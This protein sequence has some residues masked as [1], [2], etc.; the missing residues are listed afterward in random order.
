MTRSPES[1]EGTGEL[2]A[3][4]RMEI[5]D[6]RN[7]ARMQEIVARHGWLDQS[8]VGRDGAA[9]AWCLVQ[10]ADHDRDFQRQYLA[11][12]EN[13][14]GLDL[15]DRAHIAYL[16][17]RIR[18]GEER[19]QLYGTQL[20]EQ[21]SRLLPCPLKTRLMLMNDA[22]TWDCRRWLSTSRTRPPSMAFARAPLLPVPPRD[23]AQRNPLTM[24]LRSLVSTN[25]VPRALEA[26]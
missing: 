24:S 7:T 25:V 6:R 17:D 21:G 19:Q 4:R 5:V 16:I 9:A 13:A 10:L 3:G 20:R 14:A 2:R 26:R 11:L 23:V 12:M 22:R 8:I 15:V 18:V 1:L